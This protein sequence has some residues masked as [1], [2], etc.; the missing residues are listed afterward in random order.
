MKINQVI[1]L[2]PRKNTASNFDLGFL[3]PYNTQCDRNLGILFDYSL[4]LSYVYRLS[5][6][7][8]F[9]GV[10]KSCFYQL[11]LLSKVTPFLSRNNL[12]SAIHAFTV[13]HFGLIIVTLCILVFLS[14]QLVQN[15]TILLLF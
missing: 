1:L 6:I 12:N 3:T 8:R 13:Y 15:M 14:L 4:S 5:L 7:N 2:G 11:R 10:V 9:P